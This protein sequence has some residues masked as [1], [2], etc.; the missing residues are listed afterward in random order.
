MHAVYKAIT[1]ARRQR[2]QRV[3]A[4]VAVVLLV[5]LSLGLLTSCGPRG[6]ELDPRDE[7]AVEQ[8]QGSCDRSS[9]RV[10][11]KVV[12]HNSASITITLL[13]NS[14]MNRRLRSV[15]GL[16]TTELEVSRFYFGQGG[17]AVLHISGGGMSRGDFAVWLTP[18]MCNVG[19]LS[20]EPLISAS[21][22]AGADL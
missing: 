4:F 2:Q 14:G 6:V 16:S 20:I 1:V 5:I 11:L 18:L 22:F 9:S 8:F 3:A 7:A 12:N 17:Q 19:T 13:A 10:I 21:M 15:N